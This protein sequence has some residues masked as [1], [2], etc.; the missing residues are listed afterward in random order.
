VI[1]S[2]DGASWEAHGADA[3]LRGVTFKHG[4]YA[5]VGLE[6]KILTSPDTIIWTP[7]N[8][9]TTTDLY[10]IASDAHQFVA[11]GNHG[12]VLTAR[13]G[14]NWTARVSPRRQALRGIAF[15]DS[16]FVAVGDG[17]TV[18][19]SDPIP[20]GPYLGP[21]T[22]VEGGQLRLSIEDLDPGQVEIQISPDLSAWSTWTNVTTRDNRVLVID[23]AFTQ[24]RHRFYRAVVN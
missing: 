13:D 14:T 11:V 24:T 22:F 6:G 1:T 12:T 3:D 8:S 18:I 10:A 23:P 7:Q 2:P 5:A 21:L 17:W 20:Q 9:G 16:T 4:L 15:G 19:E